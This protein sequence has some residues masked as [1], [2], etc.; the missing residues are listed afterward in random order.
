[1]AWAHLRV[2]GHNLIHR[3]CVKVD[4]LG[5]LQIQL[6]YIFL[7]QSNTWAV[8]PALAHIVFHSL[9]EQRHV[10]SA[11]QAHLV[12]AP[13][14]QGGAGALLKRCARNK[15]LLNSNTLFWIETLA[16]NL[17]HKICEE[18]GR[19]VD[20][21]RAVPLAAACDPEPATI[22]Q[23]GDHAKCTTNRARPLCTSPA[24]LKNGLERDS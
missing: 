15:I 8:M 14:R 5:C 7:K 10:P 21:G 16:H 6:E 13:G 11:P 17:F 23:V 3:L 4:N 9:C 2:L 19:A 18:G 20:E 24:C 12:G 1:M 22:T